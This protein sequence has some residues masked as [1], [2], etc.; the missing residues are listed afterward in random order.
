MTNEWFLRR[1]WLSNLKIVS[2]TAENWTWIIVRPTYTSLHNFNKYIVFSPVNLFRSKDVIAKSNFFVGIRKGKSW[3]ISRLNKEQDILLDS[4]RMLNKGNSIL[5]LLPI[6]FTRNRTTLL[7]L[8]LNPL[9]VSGGGL[10]LQVLVANLIVSH[11]FVK[12][13]SLYDMD[14]NKQKILQIS[15]FNQ[16]LLLCN[17]TL[18]AAVAFAFTVAIVIVRKVIPLFPNRMAS[19]TRSVPFRQ[20]GCMSFWCRITD[21]FS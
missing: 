8:P 9:L 2:R 16:Q 7:S 10:G 4:S 15:C 14:G 19:S 20:F 21:L 11:N 5:H 6:D 3:H 1:A 18:H 12:L 13:V 17:W